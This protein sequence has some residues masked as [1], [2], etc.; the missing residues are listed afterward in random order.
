MLMMHDKKKMVP[1][2]VASIDH[3][4]FSSE[5]AVDR[6]DDERAFT[7]MAEDIIRAVNEKDARR[8]SSI[9]RNFFYSCDD[10]G[11]EQDELHIGV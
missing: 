9:L 3:Q 1:T 6:G 4:D 7:S 10:Q 8:L 5:D 2:I 11:P